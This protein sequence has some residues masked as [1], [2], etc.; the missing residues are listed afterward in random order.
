MMNEIELQSKTISF[1]RFPLSVL[2]ILVHCN[3]AS[4]ISQI[5]SAQYTLYTYI[6]NV[7]DLLFCK[8]AVPLFYIISGYLFFV[9]V[10]K[11]NAP[12]YINKL[13]S[14][15]KSLLIP[16]LFWNL[17]IIVCYAVAQ[18]LT[19][20]ILPGEKLSDYSLKEWLMSFWDASAF[21]AETGATAPLNQPLWFI[22]D[23]IIMV[24]C[25]PLIYYFIKIFR[26]YGLIVFGILYLL[27]LIPSPVG[28]S[29]SASF[30]FTLGAWFGINKQQF[31]VENIKKR[32]AISVTF[33]Y[34]LIAVLCCVFKIY[35]TWHNIILRVEII[36][37]CFLLIHIAAYF[38]KNGSWKS[39][40]FLADS[41]FSYI[42]IME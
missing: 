8:N 11:L 29:S 20:G 30:F 34:F 24:V 37:G 36:L 1:L 2:V 27:G 21:R 42:V 17:I 16:Y 38:I 4:V 33:L 9:K 41:S 25:S 39:N 12:I 3:Y 26:I 10:D 23:L 40:V 15:T 13:K 31:I 18:W 28:L 7:I 5:E 32:L 35:G 6:L 19:P 14:R 22:R